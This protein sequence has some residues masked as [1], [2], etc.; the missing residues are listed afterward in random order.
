MIIE[1]NTKLLAIPGINSNQLIFLSLVLDKN[2]KPYNQDVRRVVSLI[3]DDEIRDLIDK[4][5]IISIERGNSITYQP[6]DELEQIVKPQKDYFDLFYEM[7]PVYVLR[8]DGAKSYLRS[9]VNKCKTIFKTFTGRSEAMAE[10]IINCLDFEL[11]Q[12]M[13][14][15]KLGYMPTM[16]NWLTRRSWEAIEEEMKDNVITE[17]KSTYGTDLI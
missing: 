13:N 8:P 16:W 9:N 3:H 5:L 14:V 4:K 15:G 17:Q 11:K 12:K 10:H 2:Q 1:L 6:T 7:Y